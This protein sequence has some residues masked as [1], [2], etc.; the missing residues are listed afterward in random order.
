MKRVFVMIVTM[1][2]LAGCADKP[3]PT[4]EA[5]E[6]RAHELDVLAAERQDAKAFDLYSLR[7][8]KQ[9]GSVD[10]Y[11][12]VLDAFFAGRSPKYVSATAEVDGENG[13]VVSV[14][15]DPSAPASAREPRTWTFIDGEWKFDNC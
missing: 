7:C 11:S 14:D 4:A 6:Q 9:I 5:L 3:E 2:A 12:R 15:E 10:Q 13:T 1:S 8:Q